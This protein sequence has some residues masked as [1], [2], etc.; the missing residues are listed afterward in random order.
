M[1][2]TPP[3]HRPC[4]AARADMVP[5]NGAPAT[6]PARAGA[7]RRRGVAAVRRAIVRRHRHDGHDARDDAGTATERL[8]IAIP[9]YDGSLTP[10]TFESGYAFMSLIYDTLMWRD[11]DGVAK[12]WLARR[13]STQRGRQDGARHAAPRRALSRRRGARRARRDLLLP[14][15]PTAPAR[16]LHA[17][18]AGHRARRARR[19]PHGR[20]HAAPQVARLRG[21]A[22]G[23]RADPAAASVAG[24]RRH[25]PR[26]RPGA[27]V[28]S[29]PY[30]LDARRPP[31]RLPP[32]GQPAR[33]SAAGRPSRASTFRSSAGRTRSSRS[34]SGAAST[35]SRDDPARRHAAARDGGALS[36]TTSPTRERCSRST[37]A[38]GRSAGSSRAARLRGR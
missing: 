29:G 37:S 34:S 38:A 30:R 13:I 16:A 18:A 9:A 7:R 26:A 35:S 25:E 6:T 31:G 17:A 3:S 22:A 4:A 23:R 14:P 10:Y 8:R 12:P 1:R 11:A 24:G 36:P 19:Q 32:A 5:A 15:L 2:I 20:L 28:G 21:P 27:P 33:T